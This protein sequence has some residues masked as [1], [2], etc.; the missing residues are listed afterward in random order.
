MGVLRKGLELPR[1][2]ALVAAADGD[3]KLATTNIQLNDKLHK[4]SRYRAKCMMLTRQIVR[5]TGG[6]TRSNI[7]S[8]M[9]AMNVTLRPLHT[10]HRQK[11]KNTRDP[12]NSFLLAEDDRFTTA[13]AWPRTVS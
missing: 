5:Y 7:I 11:K 10:H 12:N 2:C 3:V 8:T 13:R 1:L 6:T 9:V 4:Q